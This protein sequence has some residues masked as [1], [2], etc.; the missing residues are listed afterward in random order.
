M[1]APL[2]SVLIP[3][4]NAEKYIGGTLDSV[5]RQTWPEIEVIVVNDGSTDRSLDEINRFASPRLT[6][7]DQE[8]RG[9]T[10]ALNAALSRARGD[11]IQY[12]DADDLISPNKVEVQLER[13]INRPRCVATAAWGRFQGH[14]DDVRF[15]RETVSRD[16][17]AIEW[18]ALSRYDALA[19]MFPALWLVPRPLAMEAGPWHEE[20]TLNNDAEYFTR[21]LLRSEAVLFCEEARCY[22]RVVPGSLSGH[23]SPAAWRSQFKVIDLCERYVRTR[24]DSDRIRYGF[25]QSWQHLAHG[26]FPYDSALAEAALARA[27]SLHAVRIRPNGGFRFRVL[28]R[29]IGWRA[30]RRLQVA[31]GRY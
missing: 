7:L 3:C 13:L 15:Q 20:L 10:A 28:S 30:A 2:V 25:A 9:Q 19:M 16:L 1:T 6:V 11:F 17:A 18:L 24:E 8:N 21:V 23:K 14:P 26:C 27:R 12:L 4:F 5:F 29:L 22:Y 31:S